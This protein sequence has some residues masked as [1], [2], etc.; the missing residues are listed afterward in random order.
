MPKPNPEQQRAI[1]APSDI[2]ILINAG[3]G[4][5]KTA[6]LADR[7]FRLVDSKELSASSL[8]ILTFTNKAAYEM[9]QRI[10]REFKER[11]PDSLQ[12]KE[13]LSAHIQTFDSFSQYLVSKY[14]IDLGI[15]KNIQ[16]ANEAILSAKRQDLLSEILLEHY[17]KHDPHIL[18]TLVK[19]DT[20]DDR[21]LR[22]LILDIDDQLQLIAPD[23]RKELLEHYDE[24]RLSRSFFDEATKRFAD[25]IRGEMIQGFYRAYFL[26]EFYTDLSSLSDQDLKYHLASMKDT[27]E[28]YHLLSF[29]L[30][31]AQRDFQLLLALVDKN[32][33][34]FFRELPITIQ[35]LGKK[36]PVSKED[37]EPGDDLAYCELHRLITTSEPGI[38][39][40][41]GVDTDIEHSYQKLLS[42]RDDIHLILAI[43]KEL[44]ERLWSYKRVTNTFTFSDVSGLALKLMKDPAYETIAE[45]IRSRFTYI[46]VDEYQDTNDFQEEFLDSLRKHG[47]LFVVGDPKQSIY[48]FR[49]SNVQLFH[50]REKQFSSDDDSVSQVIAMNTNYRSTKPILEDINRIFLRYMTKDH[51]DIDFSNPSQQ[52]RY[53][54]KANLY[55]LSSSEYG[56]H[57]IIY[58]AQES[59]I[60]DRRKTEAIAIIADIKKKM[61]DPSFLIYDLK[62]GDK[63]TH[64]RRVRY[65][66]FAILSC[67]KKNF[68]P[69]QELFLQAGIPLDNN[70]ESNLR[71]VAAI[72]FLESLI[73][74]ISAF[75]N[76]DQVNF[77]HLFASLARSYVYG[78]QAGYDDEKIH[79]VLSDP[80]GLKNDSIM[81]DIKAF[82][83][84]NQNRPF[85]SIFLNMLSSFHVIERLVSLGDVEDNVSKIE[86]LYAIIL[87]QEKAGEGMH[88]FVELFQS[89][90]R[91]SL[92]LSA[93]SVLES[94]DAVHMMTI[95]GS[96]GLEF[97]IVYM[98]VSDNAL[99]GG[100]NRNAPDYEFSKDYGI[101]LHD[102]Q[103]NEFRVDEEGNPLPDYSD[104]ILSKLYA[105][106]EGSAQGSIDEHVRLFYV[107]FTRA[108]DALIFVGNE[109]QKGQKENLYQMLD[110]T[111]H[112]RTMNAA[113]L[114]K[115]IKEGVISEKEYTDFQNAEKRMIL[116][117]EAEFT[118]AAFSSQAC[119]NGYREFYENFLL[120]D[121]RNQMKEMSE[122]MLDQI[123][124]DLLQKMIDAPLETKLSFYCLREFKVRNI[125]KPD[126]LLTCRN[127]EDLLHLADHIDGLE[128]KLEEYLRRIESDDYEFFFRKPPFIKHT[129]K[130]NHRDIRDLFLAALCDVL[131]GFR[132]PLYYEAYPYVDHD[133]A[134][135]FFEMSPELLQGQAKQS[136]ISPVQVSTAEIQ[137]PK[138]ETKK[139]ASKKLVP[140]DTA[141]ESEEDNELKEKL[142]TEEGLTSEAEDKVKLERGIYLHHLLELVDFHTKDTSFIRYQDPSPR[143]MKVGDRKLIDTILALPL[144][145]DLE[146]SEIYQEYSY[147]D[148]VYKTNGS[149]D[150]LMKKPNGKFIIVDYKTYHID[151]PAYIEQLKVYRRNVA[152]L[153]H[154][155][156]EDISL[157]LLSI[158]SATIKKIEADGVLLR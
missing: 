145:D 14:A 155:K 143:H 82:C 149:I 28:D 90:N 1:D 64:R 131:D 134:P 52:L 157:Y 66:D 153:F 61:N 129:P 115:K 88:E 22:K 141:R 158:E 41:L 126:D 68:A 74:C 84:E 40:I 32:G 65:S 69:F 49:N 137:F 24:L 44:D 60:Y 101:L 112:H 48:A 116:L 127:G 26:Q 5:G 85:S 6:T 81:Q 10:I 140:I 33:E 73:K 144:F 9:K 38:P 125:T 123:Y 119:F 150:L 8:L 146:G 2:N 105:K 56:I 96:K 79:R 136:V 113:Y 12:A 46:M 35:A 11:D 120:S 89:F 71:D 75:L 133:K 72:I 80:D 4:S 91:H 97:P 59:G 94:E 87:S 111:P 62:N 114:K 78:P 86:S 42:F 148:E 63:K 154:V 31:Y 100:D 53:D 132:E 92:S 29:R 142:A 99:M 58:S 152:Y 156:E 138:S 34:D 13:I 102:Y 70:L 47:H 139:R 54:E 124:D 110:T 67:K 45:E 98:Q 128:I 37:V 55:P 107:A 50:R 21:E 57:R 39:S 147:Y 95:H 104:T 76:D 135:T 103:L 18:K 16:I 121:Y 30:E 118:P 3:A 15:S 83:A 19:F 27:P 77:R 51:G 109:E 93:Q 7:V 25:I 117:T 151:D 17:A 122:S 130:Q 43:V 106:T 36:K 23:K 108:K 20:K